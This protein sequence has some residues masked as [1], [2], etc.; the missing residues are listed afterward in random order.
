MVQCKLGRSA[1]EERILLSPWVDSGKL[2]TMARSTEA[3][4]DRDDSSKPEE[5]QTSTAG[6]GEDTSVQNAEKQG[7]KR[8]VGEYPSK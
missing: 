4:N 8:D 5:K 3:Q 1:H 6:S 2:T 7:W